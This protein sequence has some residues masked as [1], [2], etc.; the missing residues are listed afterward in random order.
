MAY[1]NDALYIGQNAHH[2]GGF[3]GAV[4]SY[5]LL[6]LGGLTLALILSIALILV[7]LIK[8]TGFSLKDVSSLVTQKVVDAVENCARKE[9]SYAKVAKTTP[10]LP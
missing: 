3:I 9:T 7:C 4:L 10:S 8:I 1:I 5:P 6:K 2:G